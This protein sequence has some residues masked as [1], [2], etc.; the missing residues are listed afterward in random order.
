MTATAHPHTVTIELDNEPLA[1]VPQHTT[2]NEI[3]SLGGID[4][5][6]HYLERVTGHHHE[7]F[8][9]RGDEKITVHNGEKFVS[10]YTG[11]TT[12]S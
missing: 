1:G 8:K 7:S 4:P 12:T 2:P 11:P 10:L 6:Q 3:M 5:A 9:D